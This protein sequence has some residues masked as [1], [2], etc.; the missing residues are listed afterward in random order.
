MSFKTQAEFF[1][2]ILSGGK[3]KHKSWNHI[4]GYLELKNESL[5]DS[6]GDERHCDNFD[7]EYYEIYTEPEKPKKLLQC[8]FLDNSLCV[9]KIPDC[10]FEDEFTAKKYAREAGETFVKVINEYD[11]EAKEV[12]I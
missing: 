12:E 10:L 7:Y 2:Y 9:Y 11:I 6:D 1:K 4:D 8:L 5:F 3:F